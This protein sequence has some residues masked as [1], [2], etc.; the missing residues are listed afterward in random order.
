MSTALLLVVLLPALGAD[1]SSAG[2]PGAEL[3]SAVAENC[4]TPA[5]TGSP[6]SAGVGGGGGRSAGRPTPY[7]GGP[8]AA[9]PRRR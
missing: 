6:P 9:G 7:P 3:D 1:R 5:L 4:H 2:V 8:A